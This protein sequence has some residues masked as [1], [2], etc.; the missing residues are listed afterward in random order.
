MTG[1]FGG[2]LTAMITPFKGDKVNFDCL[3]KL[4][5]YQIKGGADGLV[6]LGTTGEPST[7]SDEEKQETLSFCINKAAGAIKIIA[8]V[9]SNDTKKAVAAAINAQKSGAD[10]VLAV[11]PYY[12]KCTQNGIVEYYKAICRATTL[13]TIAYNVPSRTGVNITVDTAKKLCEIKNMAGIKEASG[14]MSQVCSIMAAVRGK[15]D[16]FSG[17]D[18][19]NLP[20]LAVGGAG[21]ISVVSNLVPDKVK[22]VY[23]L[24]KEGKLAEANLLQDSL[25]PLIESCF[26]EVNP[27]PVKYGCNIL[28]F[29]AG[30]PRP[31]LTPIEKEHGKIL[32][33]NLK[34][35]V[36]KND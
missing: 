33:A 24:V 14:N 17:E 26:I 9:G 20:I 8:G 12:N 13:P 6:V 36:K 22:R 30:D 4:I 23:N 11:T 28:G 21:V 2:V 15:I 18:C 32:A 31:P 16:V 35:A 5:E 34:K 3:S 1:A 25:L 19:L 7:M 29:E 27:I 10:G